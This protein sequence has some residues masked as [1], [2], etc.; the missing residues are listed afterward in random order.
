MV[1]FC[2]V[3][4]DHEILIAPRQFE[5]VFP[6]SKTQEELFTNVQVAFVPDMVEF[7]KVTLF[8]VLIE[9]MFHG[10]VSETSIPSTIT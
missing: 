7:V 8:E 10:I 2:T 6:S 1:L 4:S 9:T 5:T 3:A